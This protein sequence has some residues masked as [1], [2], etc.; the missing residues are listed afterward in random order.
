MSENTTIRRDDPD[1]PALQIAIHHA[2]IGLLQSTL[3]VVKD[4]VGNFQ[5]HPNREEKNK[6]LSAAITLAEHWVTAAKSVLEIE[7]L[8]AA[9]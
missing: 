2:N 9:E 5:C 4:R 7:N 8:R 6:S 3:D 1:L